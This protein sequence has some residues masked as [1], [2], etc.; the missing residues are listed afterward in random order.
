MIN[1]NKRGYIPIYSIFFSV[2]ISLISVLILQHEE[3]KPIS[4]ID[5]SAH[6]RLNEFNTRFNS[7]MDSLEKEMNIR[8]LRLESVI[9]KRGM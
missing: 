1:D 4:V 7:K 9:C 5:K 3:S 8:L 6:S 2:S